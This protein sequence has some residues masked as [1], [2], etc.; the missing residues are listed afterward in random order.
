MTSICRE[1][2]VIVPLVVL[3]YHILVLVW[4]EAIERACILHIRVV[5]LPCLFMV[6]LL[7]NSFLIAMFLLLRFSKNL[8]MFLYKDLFYRYVKI[9]ELQWRAVH[10]MS[11]NLNSIWAMFST[12]YAR[13]TLGGT[14][15]NRVTNL[16]FKLSRCGF[17]RSKSFYFPL[18]N[19]IAREII[20]AVCSY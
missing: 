9:L 11:A 7:K 2:Y 4:W 13:A 6:A 8:F 1:R 12:T 5:W 17:N 15:A 16:R 14:C 3:V 10:Q 20:H 18:V 19:H